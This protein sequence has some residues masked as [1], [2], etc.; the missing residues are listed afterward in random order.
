M[1]GLMAL[2]ALGLA[3]IAGTLLDFVQPRWG[4]VVGGIGRISLASPF[5]KVFCRVGRDEAFAFTHQATLSFADGRKV[6]FP[7]DRAMYARFHAP[8]QYRNVYGAVLAFAP[9]LPAPTNAAVLAFGFCR[10]GELLAMAPGLTS[11]ERPTHV[12][13]VSAP[14]P[15]ASGDRRVL[16]VACPQ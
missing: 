15:G 6:R 3:T 13:I 9:R 10:D 4:R 16:E 7:L 1:A 8:Y 5:P 14:R 12:T 2:G 11:G